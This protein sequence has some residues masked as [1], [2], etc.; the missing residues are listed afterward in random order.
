MFSL[1]LKQTP[2][3]LSR[4]LLVHDRQ[5]L[6]KNQVVYIALPRKETFFLVHNKHVHNTFSWNIRIR[7]IIPNYSLEYSPY[8]T[9]TTTE[10]TV[11]AHPVITAS[12]RRVNT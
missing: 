10:I 4:H 11:H 5:T 7:M 3:T 2:V 8:D 9:V 12:L 1:T 6:N